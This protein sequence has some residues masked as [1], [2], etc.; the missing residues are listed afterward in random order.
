M[1]PDSSRKAI[2][3]P[4]RKASRRIRG[5]SSAFQ[6]STSLSLP[7]PLLRFVA[8]VVQPLLEQL[9]D[10]FGVIRD[11]EA[12]LDEL[13]NPSGG[14]QLVGEAVDSRSLR[15]KLLQFGEASLAETTFGTRR[16]LGGE[17]VRLASH[18]APTVQGS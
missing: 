3:A 14:P 12:T 15:E 18:P 13:G 2:W 1:K 4:R 7:R 17:A 9:A 10:V 8:T 11:A 5:N 6:R 16:G